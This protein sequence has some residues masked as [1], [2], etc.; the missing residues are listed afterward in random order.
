MAD[1]VLDV[2]SAPATPSAGQG[3]LSVNTTTKLLMTTNDAGLR[4]SLNFVNFS[5]ASQAPGAATRTY[6]TGSNIAFNAGGLQAAT[7][8]RWTFNMTKTGAGTAAST[9]DIAFGT[10]GTTAD[11]ARVS[12]TKPAGTAA[13]DEANVIVTCII[14]TIGATGVAVGQFSLT[15]NL[16]A[17]GHAIIPCVSVNTVSAGFDMTTVSNVGVCI[18]SGAA[19]AITIELCTAEAFNL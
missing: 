14:R 3:I 4:K 11:T 9:F 7:I 19:D 10:A 18:T 2:Q 15:H 8:L 6:I 12:F 5:T 1:I 17:T 13:I 16:A